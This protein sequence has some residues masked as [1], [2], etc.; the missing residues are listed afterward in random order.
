[1]ADSKTDAGANVLRKFDPLFRGKSGYLGA[2][3]VNS[4]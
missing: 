2:M 3:N 4:A 1:V